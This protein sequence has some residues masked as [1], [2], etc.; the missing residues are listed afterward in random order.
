[1]K[2]GSGRRPAPMSTTSASS[3]SDRNDAARWRHDLGIGGSSEGNRGAGAADQALLTRRLALVSHLEAPT[4]LFD[5]RDQTSEDFWSFLQL[6]T[7]LP[8]NICY[9]LD[10]I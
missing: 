3:R 8:P 4:S 10:V 9:K 7:F 1:M 2:S 6:R 5:G